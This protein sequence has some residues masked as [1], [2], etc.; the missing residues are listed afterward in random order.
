LIV[1]VYAFAI[2]AFLAIVLML[3]N[4]PYAGFVLLGVVFV[5]AA[6]LAFSAWNHISTNDQKLINPSTLIG[7][8]EATKTYPHV[9]PARHN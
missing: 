7:Y 3:G 5:Q 1:Q 9:D 8:E 4:V 6:M 2:L